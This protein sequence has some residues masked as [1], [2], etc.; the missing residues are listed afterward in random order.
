MQRSVFRLT[1]MQREQLLLHLINLIYSRAWTR[2]GT[3]VFEEKRSVC[4]MSSYCTQ[5]T[6]RNI[7]RRIC[8]PAD[9]CGLTTQ[10]VDSYCWQYYYLPN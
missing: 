3:C 10:E 8:I 2:K 5:I 1:K 6:Q 4:N 7:S 9:I